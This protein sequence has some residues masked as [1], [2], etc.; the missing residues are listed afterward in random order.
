[1]SLSRKPTRTARGENLALLALI[2][3]LILTACEPRQTQL[4]P[5]LAPTQPPPVTVTLPPPPPT[6]TPA[7]PTPT[8]TQPPGK[9]IGSSCPFKLPPS[10]NEGVNVECGYLVVPSDRSDPS[11]PGLQLAVA[12]LRHPEG[13][14]AGDPIVYLEGGPGGSALEF[15]NLVYDRRYAPVF[16]AGRDIILFDQRGDGFGVERIH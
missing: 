13:D 11:S 3:I 8:P 12:I 16:E 6:N 1:M 2:V 4:P 5:T 14:A 7:P 9:F 15:L 10:L